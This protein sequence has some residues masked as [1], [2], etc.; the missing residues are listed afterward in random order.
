MAAKVTEN[1]EKLSPL[2]TKELMDVVHHGLWPDIL[3]ERSEEESF[4]PS[5][6]FL[7]ATYF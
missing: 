7:H 2:T 6:V 4:F 5:V 1:L 3:D